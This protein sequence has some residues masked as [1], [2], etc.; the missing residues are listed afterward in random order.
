MSENAP[1]S[2]R[3]S[4]NDPRELFDCLGTIGRGSYGSVYRARELSSQNIVAIKV[5]SMDPSVGS[6]ATSGGSAAEEA[7]SELELLES[8]LVAFPGGGSFVELAN[9]TLSM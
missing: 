7:K 3:E 1:Q 2:P 4:A 9:T 5:V 8:C 6:G